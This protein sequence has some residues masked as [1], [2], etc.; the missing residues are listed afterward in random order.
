[1]ADRLY[2]DKVLGSKTIEFDDYWVGA[3][4]HDIGKLVLGLYFWD[5]FEVI[6]NE[7]VRKNTS[8]RTVEAQFGSVPNHEYIG[9]I[10]LLKANM[11]PDIVNWVGNHD[12]IGESPAVE[13]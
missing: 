3:L 9:Q 2:T 4:L 6:L 12:T 7:M 13:E 1:M 10:L 11:G 5:H 8:F